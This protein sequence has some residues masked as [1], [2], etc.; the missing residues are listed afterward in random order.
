M[1]RHYGT[2]GRPSEIYFIISRS[3]ENISNYHSFFLDSFLSFVLLL[4]LGLKQFD[5]VHSE[6]YSKYNYIKR[7]IRCTRCNISAHDS[8]LVKDSLTAL[9]RYLY[10]HSQ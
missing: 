3:F 8:R 9:Q 7:N 2:P 6:L 5:N 4:S 1:K 10:S